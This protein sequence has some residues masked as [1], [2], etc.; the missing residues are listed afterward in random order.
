MADPLQII[1]TTNADRF[2]FENVVEILIKPTEAGLGIFQDND[3]WA[4]KP[5]EME[6]TNETLQMEQKEV[7][8]EPCDAG[9]NVRRRSAYWLGIRTVGNGLK[10]RLTEWTK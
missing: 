3:G 10:R 6:V 4:V 7:P 2:I 5:R 8:A 1:V 9:R